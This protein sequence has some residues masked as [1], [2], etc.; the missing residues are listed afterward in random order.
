MF[1]DSGEQIQE[2]QFQKLIRMPTPMRNNQRL[3]PVESFPEESLARRNDP[4]LTDF[5]KLKPKL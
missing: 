5:L 3:L 4:V 2:E 1:V